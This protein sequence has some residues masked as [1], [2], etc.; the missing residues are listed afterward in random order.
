MKA[1]MTVYKGGG[2]APVSGMGKKVVKYQMGGKPPIKP[3]VPD[4]KKELLKGKGSAA[5]EANRAESRKQME[6]DAN[7]VRRQE[8]INRANKVMA[9]P[10]FS[11]LQKQRAASPSY[12]TVS[13]QKQ[14]ISSAERAGASKGT[15]GSMTPTAAK[16]SEK[17]IK[18][19]P[20]QAAPKRAPEPARAPGT[21]R[22]ETI[23]AIE[24][25]F[26]PEANLRR[27]KMTD[28]SMAANPRDAQ[29]IRE[30]E[31]LRRAAATAQKKK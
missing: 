2:K 21:L 24:M 23:R 26:T 7:V 8:A 15:V 22:P 31:A 4:K 14:G 30:R 28:A 16:R 29:V 11:E 20:V 3:I 18:N 10:A 1:K 9:S 5:Y 25:G 13:G 6:A 12:K 27:A 19:P 17:N